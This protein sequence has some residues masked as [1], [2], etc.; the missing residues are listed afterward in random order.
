MALWKVE[1]NWKKS[2]T[3]IQYWTKD[4]KTIEYEEGWRWGTFY[5]YKE[6]DEPPEIEGGDDLFCI[7]HCDLEDWST[8]DGCWSDYTFRN[9]TDEEE[10]EIQA[11]FDDGNCVYDL[12]EQGWVCSETEMILG[13]DVTI[14]K[15]PDDQ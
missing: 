2:L 12:E 13:C 3:E 15:Q 11:F 8:D 5:Y 1:P 4:G 6:G 7:D 9:M 14:E 10:E